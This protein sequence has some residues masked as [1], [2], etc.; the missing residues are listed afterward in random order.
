[1]GNLVKMPYCADA[2]RLQFQNLFIYNVPNVL[3]LLNNC[4]NQTDSM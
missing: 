4:S 2:S 3:C 1:M